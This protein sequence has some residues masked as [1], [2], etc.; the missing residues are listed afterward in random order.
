MSIIWGPEAKSISRR[1]E[2]DFECSIFSAFK[3]LIWRTT[4]A[5][6][7]IEI[8]HIG[9]TKSIEEFICSNSH[10]CIGKVACAYVMRLILCPFVWSY[11]LNRLMC[12]PLINQGDRCSEPWI[13]VTNSKLGNNN[14]CGNSLFIQKRNETSI[15]IIYCL[16]FGILINVS[17]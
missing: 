14:T 3:E 1:G 17:L 9:N 10:W 8:G 13:T 11:F 6:C 2:F 12:R 15:D 7:S 4:G 16:I 5:L